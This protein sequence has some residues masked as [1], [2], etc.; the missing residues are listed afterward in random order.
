MPDT[1]SS[2]VVASRYDIQIVDST[3]SP[4]YRDYKNLTIR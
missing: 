2:A 3:H 1:V 4:L